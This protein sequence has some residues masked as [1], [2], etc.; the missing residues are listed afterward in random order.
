MEDPGGLVALG[1][2]GPHRG[3]V[4]V[5]VRGGV[6]VHAESLGSVTRAAGPVR[7]GYPFTAPV[8]TRV[9]NPPIG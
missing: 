9:E 3:D 4:P 2:G 1:I 8:V 6:V 7:I 5:G